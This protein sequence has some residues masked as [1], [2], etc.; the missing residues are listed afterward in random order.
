MKEDNIETMM[1]TVSN[2]KMP[3]TTKSPEEIIRFLIQKK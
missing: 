2:D 1:K 3:E